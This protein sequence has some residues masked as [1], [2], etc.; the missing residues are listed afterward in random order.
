MHPPARLRAALAALPPAEYRQN[1]FRTV[2]P[3]YLSAPYVPLSGAGARAHGAR[4][5]PPGTFDTLYLAEDP[6][7]A[8]QEYHHINLQLMWDMD[9]QF[10]ARLAV[11]A[12]LVPQAVLVPTRVLDLTRR[13]VRTAL[14]TDLAEITGPWR[15]PA[16]PPSPPTHVLGQE[17]FNSGLFRGI[18]FPSARRPGGV[19]LA[20]FSARL[21]P[22]GSIDLDDSRNGGP[23]QHLP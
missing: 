5:T 23:V 11:T 18:R 10:A 7:T 4:Y 1:L 6:L 13:E 20:V 14:G 3:K 17:A 12:M 21:A 19:Y 16:G 9:D 15:V 2:L 8:F 22:G